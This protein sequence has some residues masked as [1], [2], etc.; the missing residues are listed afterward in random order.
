M[1]IAYRV[2][3]PTGNITVLV[4]TAVPVEAQPDI[5]AKLMALEPTA[6]QVGFLASDGAAD[7]AL[8]MAGGEFCG[9]AT[10]CAAVCAAEA[11]GT[12]AGT[13]A[14]RVSG[15]D[16]PVRAA[17]ARQPDGSLRCTVDMPRP[18]AIEA[19]MLP[20]VGEVRVVRFPGISHIVLEEPM[21]RPLAERNA[22]LWCGALGADALGLLFLDRRTERLTPL[23]YVPA[24]GTLFWESSCASGTAA[25]GAYLARDGSA[26]TATLLQP[27]GELTIAAD[28]TGTLRLTGT[29]RAGERKETEI[30]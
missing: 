21:P 12:D 10:M 20:G 13:F 7:I 30:G 8:R 3:D 27:G 26:V 24:A 23:V 14:V 16:A 28:E 22:R 18:E 5:A 4:E 17:V 9:N 15:A 29:V 2:F 1:K 25:V 11:A 19:R 6:E